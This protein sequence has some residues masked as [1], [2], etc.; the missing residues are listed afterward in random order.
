M[1]TRTIALFVLFTPLGLVSTAQAQNVEYATRDVRPTHA[2]RFSS[3]P[4]RITQTIEGR[5]TLPLADVDRSFQTNRRGRS[6]FFGRPGRLHP[7]GSIFIGGRGAV[8]RSTEVVEREAE[9]PRTVYGSE[10][11]R[12]ASAPDPAADTAPSSEPT[13]PST[14]GDAASAAKARRQIAIRYLLSDGRGPAAR[15]ADR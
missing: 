10:L 13:P 3:Q 4:L 2:I 8:I 14:G 9:R 15:A 6:I 1:K 7:R 12:R 5:R 11:P